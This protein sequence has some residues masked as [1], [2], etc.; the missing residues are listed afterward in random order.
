MGVTKLSHNVAFMSLVSRHSLTDELVFVTQANE[1]T[2][3]VGLVAGI[4]MP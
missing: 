4:I 2:N 1:L 3:Y